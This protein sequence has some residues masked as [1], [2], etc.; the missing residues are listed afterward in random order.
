MKIKRV[1]YPTLY[2]TE[3]ISYDYPSHCSKAIIR[4]PS[5]INLSEIVCRTGNLSNSSSND[6]AWTCETPS[7]PSGKPTS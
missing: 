1:G 6:D 4:L 3:L 7:N 2:E 5:Q